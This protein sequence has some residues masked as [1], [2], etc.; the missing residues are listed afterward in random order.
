M[1]AEREGGCACGA[2]RYRI[3]G[4]PIFVNNCHCTLCQKQTGGTSVVNAF[5]ESEAVTLLSGELSHHVVQTGSGGDQ[6]IFRCVA[7]GTALW[8]A[9]PRLGDVGLGLRVATLDDAR[10]LTP[11]AVIFTDSAMPWVTLPQ[12]IPHFA[13]TYRFDEVLPPDR[14]VRMQALV[15]KRAAQ[16]A[17]IA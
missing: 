11:D 16:K 4:D 6:N 9:Y 1:T 2:V 8:S 3:M 5:I 13:T 17:A 15:E 10:S 14:L 7:C 12:G